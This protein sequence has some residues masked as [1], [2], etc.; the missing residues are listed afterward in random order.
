M[1]MKQL[2]NEHI[3]T[4]SRRRHKRLHAEYSPQ[5]QQPTKFI[6]Y[7]PCESG[8][9]DCSTSHV[10]SRCSFDLRVIFRSLLHWIQPLTSLVSIHLL[11]LEVC[12]FFFTWPHK[13]TQLK[14]HAYLLM[15][16]P[17]TMSLHWKVWW[18]YPFFWWF[19]GKMLHWKYESYKYEL[20]MKKLSW[21]VNYKAIKMS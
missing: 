1:L 3:K 18:P 17:C 20:S 4:R 11:L 13:T 16:T 12:V 14:F 2:V 6:S 7:K 5:S 21:L 8:D 15:R 19:R 9:M 10:T